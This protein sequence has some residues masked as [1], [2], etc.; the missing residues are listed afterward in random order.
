MYMY[1]ITGC[2]IV[3][4]W[5]AHRKN[6]LFPL[7]YHKILCTLATVTS[8]GENLSKRFFFSHAIFD[9]YPVWTNFYHK[10]LSS[11]VVTEELTA[12]IGRIVRGVSC[13]HKKIQW[14]VQSYA[15]DITVT[16]LSRLTM[17]KFSQLQKTPKN[18]RCWLL[19]TWQTIFDIL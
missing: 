13:A 17:T 10:L 7:S 6:W 1:F 2:K 9:F 11:S 12:W 14:L 16:V 18:L 3:L 4:K 8:E 15:H 19:T 5:S